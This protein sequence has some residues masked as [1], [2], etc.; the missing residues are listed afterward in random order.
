MRIF[1]LSFFLLIPSLK[2]IELKPWFGRA[3]EIETRSS[4]LFQQY[5]EIASDCGSFK[6][7]S[8]DQFA[9]LSGAI[10]FDTVATEVEVNFGHTSKNNFN[11]ECARLLASY[12]VLDDVTFDKFSLLAGGVATFANRPFVNDISAFFHGTLEFEA[13]LSFGKEISS[14]AAWLTRAWGVFGFGVASLGKPWI[15][16]DAHLEQVLWKG[17]RVGLSSYY[18]FGLGEDPLK[19][20]VVFKGYGPIRH[21]SLDLGVSLTRVVGTCGGELEIEYAKRVYARNFPSGVDLI[22]LT[23]Y[24]PFGL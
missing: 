23:F 7:S 5:D 13:F 1:Y 15:R 21:R 10:A 8:F 14:R 20:C 12:L 2:A 18:L 16:A 24:Y 6:S 11:F 22:K 3:V 17:T 19:K 4:C 9:A